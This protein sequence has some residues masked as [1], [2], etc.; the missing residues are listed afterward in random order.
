M[1]A[2]DSLESLGKRRHLCYLFLEISSMLQ[3][4]YFIC[5]ESMSGKYR[6]AFVFNF[7]YSVWM[8][9]VRHTVCRIYSMSS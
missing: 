6:K 1:R 8:N 5:V 9:T 3:N 7:N 4:A 2:T